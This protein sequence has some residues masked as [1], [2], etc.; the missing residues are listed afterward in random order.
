MIFFR[1]IANVLTAILFGIVV[2]I[3]AVWMAFE[4]RY[5]LELLVADDL[6]GPF[7]RAGLPPGRCG[8]SW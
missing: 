6:E 7:A 2:F 3:A 8:G 5:F 4:G 1:L